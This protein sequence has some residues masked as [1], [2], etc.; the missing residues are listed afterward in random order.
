[1]RCKKVKRLIDEGIGLS[2]KSV[3]K[4]IRSCPSCARAAEAAGI[5]RDSIKAAR[6]NDNFQPT[7]LAFIRSRVEALAGARFEKETIMTAIK[8]QYKAR[9]G[10]VAGLGVAIIAFLFITLV[11]F[12]YTRTVGYTATI[13]GVDRSV[14]VTL[15]QFK[16]AIKALG[17]DDVI[18][19]RLPD[20]YR[21]ANL[22]SKEAAQKVA[23][24]FAVM[25]GVESTAKIEPV[26]KHT[27]GS[28][29][30]QVKEKLKVKIDASGMSDTE[31]EDAIRSKLTEAGFVNIDVQ[32]TTPSDG[33]RRISIRM[34]SPEPGD[35]AEK[36]EFKLELRDDSDD[37]FFDLPDKDRIEVETEGKTIE[38]IKAEVLARLAE[39]GITDAQVDVKQ[40]P[41]GK[42]EILVNVEKEK[43]IRK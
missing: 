14:D 3:T 1:M 18:V 32:V 16:G 22:S 4:H 31:I 17:Y 9:P 10:L 26:V 8:K 28:L 40:R 30:A 27:S 5:L 2:D 39:R 43:E 6:E 7:S 29:Y 21:V 37:I 34:D 33:E 25:S 23:G 19:E 38:E 20:G 15:E 41:D 36:G 12:S 35:T 42:V 11:P 13:S 24:A